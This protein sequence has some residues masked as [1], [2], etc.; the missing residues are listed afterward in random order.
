MELVKVMSRSP[1]EWLLVALCLTGSCCCAAAGCAIGGRSAS[2]D[3]NSR[4]PFIG[5]EFLERQRKSDGPPIHSIR[6]DQNLN[7]RIKPVG[8]KKLPGVRNQTGER[9]VPNPNVQA[10][11][12]L[13]PATLPRTDVNLLGRSADR[14]AGQIDFQ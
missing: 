3:S 9:S 1:R 2:I 13:A 14:L 10:P 12:R 5:L 6:S 8:L 11:G 7:V 4:I